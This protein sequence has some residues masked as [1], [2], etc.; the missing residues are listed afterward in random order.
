VFS[1]MIVASQEPSLTLSMDRAQGGPRHQMSKVLR[2]LA[3][4]SHPEHGRLSPP[5]PMVLR[6]C[7][8][9]E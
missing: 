2:H 8:T 9:G 1:P 3:A 7:H 6:G 5:A 4:R